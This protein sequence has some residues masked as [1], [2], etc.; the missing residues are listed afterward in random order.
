MND[1][2]SILV[3]FYSHSGNTRA[4]GSEI[5]QALGADVDEIKLSGESQGALRLASHGL[6][7]VAGRSAAILP[8]RKD[9]AQ[10]DLV[11]IGGPVYG[12]TVS[13]PV[14]AYLNQQKAA[15]K[16][17]AFFTTSMSH[18]YQSTLDKM[19]EI[20]GQTPVGVLGVP[21]SELRANAYHAQVQAFC[22][23]VTR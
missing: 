2:Q 4:V 13:S 12:M 21:G 9:P 18:R 7:A 3:V 15:L 6:D 20:V 22:A 8:P 11:I 10:Y 23:Q 17:V 19:G 1:K 5:A 16:R 14:R